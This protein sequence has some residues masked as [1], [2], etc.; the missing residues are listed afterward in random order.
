MGQKSVG[1]E[2]PPTTAGRAS[3]CSCGRGFSPDA[4]RSD[5]GV[6]PDKRKASGPQTL[7][8]H[9]QKKSRLNLA[10]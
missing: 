5:R 3:A 9:A 4:V 2:G 1:P 10:G 6:A 8:Q 7:P